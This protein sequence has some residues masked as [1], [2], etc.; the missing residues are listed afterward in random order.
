M[1]DMSLLWPEG[2]EKYKIKKL[3]DVV[4]E[5]LEINTF[6]SKIGYDSEEAEFIKNILINFCT[7]VDVIKYRQEIFEDFLNCK[8]ITE[9]FES[10]LPKFSQLNNLN[11]YD[12]E[13]MNLWKFITRLKELE[14]YID[15]INEIKSKFK[16]ATIKS[17]GLLKF[18]KMIDELS[19]DKSFE[20]LS[21]DIPQVTAERDEI[22][23]ITLGINLDSSLEPSEAILLSVNKT[24][25]SESLFMKNFFSS[26]TKI[27]Q[28]ASNAASDYLNTALTKIHK[29][30]YNKET[31]MLYH[32]TRDI[33]RF[34]KS[35]TK[36][37]TKLLIKY[38]DISALKITFL[39]PEIVFYMR[40]SQFI[41]NM[42]SKNIPF[43]KAEIK[44]VQDRFSRVRDLYSINLA[45]NL[46]YNNVKDLKRNIIA[47]DLDFN[48]EGR[49]FILTGPNR[50]GKT[51]YTEA[52][53]MAQVFFQTGAYVPA[54]VAVLSP[55]DSIFTHFPVSEDKTINL[56]R[57]GEEA[58]RLN[59]IFR[60]ATKYSLILLNE[61]LSSTSYTESL[62]MAKDVAKALR[63]L[64]VRAIFNTHLHELANNIEE[65]NDNVDGKSKILSMITVMD[66]NNRSYKV[67]ISPPL[68]TSYAYDI[69]KKYGISFEQIKSMVDAM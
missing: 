33:E 52:I 29:L 4:V 1:N 8:E 60:N 66:G 3:D 67:K 68:G 28:N 23:S 5:N 48:D 7:D 30:G 54:K 35:T 50:G 31:P 37:I 6:C 62:Y 51:T 25:Y 56:G 34:I 14:V 41:N 38:M 49:I 9:C 53:G 39:Q 63:Y 42:M 26:W 36:H 16:S 61:S 10:I 58:K 57:L 47:N 15:C 21:K 64:G 46:E 12:L 2:M 65:L 24:K 19:N 45:I 59:N 43:C 17:R 11:S 22:R 18:Y 40:M 44:N 55:V 20:A 69:S 13:E 32:M 27:N